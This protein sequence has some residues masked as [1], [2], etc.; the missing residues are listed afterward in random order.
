MLESHLKFTSRRT[1]PPLHE[2]LNGLWLELDWRSNFLFEERVWRKFFSF[3]VKILRSLVTCFRVNGK[4]NK[5]DGSLLRIDCETRRCFVTK[6]KGK[7]LSKSRETND[8]RVKVKEVK[9]TFKQM[10]SGKRKSGNWKWNCKTYVYNFML[11]WSKV[12]S[13]CLAPEKLNIRRNSICQ[14]YL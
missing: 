6:K 13:S 12:L 4:R 2:F 14:N 5:L 1:Q 11:C 3:W 8:W 10:P 9:W 7:K